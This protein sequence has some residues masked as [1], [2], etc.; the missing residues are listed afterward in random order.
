METRRKLDERGEKLRN[1]DDKAADLESS[2]AGFAD[3]ARQLKEQQQR[4]AAGKWW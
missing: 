3:M 2:A 4:K 1:L